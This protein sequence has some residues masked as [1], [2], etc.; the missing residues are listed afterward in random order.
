MELSPKD[1]PSL[2]RLQAAENFF[3]KMK[4]RAEVCQIVNAIFENEVL[5]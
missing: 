1:A 4:F 3:Q 5:L 2:F